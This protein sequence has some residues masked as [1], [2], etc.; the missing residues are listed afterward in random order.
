MLP[1]PMFS[2]EMVTSARRTRYFIVRVLYAGVLFFALFCTYMSASHDNGLSDRAS[3]AAFTWEFFVIFS[4]MQLLAVVTLGPAMAAGTIAQERER[5]TIEYLFASTLSNA[6]IVLGKLLARLFQV[7]YLVLAGMPILFIA[8][9][10]GGIAPEAIVVL[11]DKFGRAVFD[12]S[13]G[14]DRMTIYRWREGARTLGILWSTVGEQS[15]TLE[16]AAPRVT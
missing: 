16:T 5:R 13:L 15:V 6:E 2:L 9:L 10:M 11:T 7:G 8:M 14:S 4:I 1:G 12:K 3:I